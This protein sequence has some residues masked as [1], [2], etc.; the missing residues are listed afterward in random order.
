MPDR[1]RSMEVF[2]KVAQLGS[3][4]AAGRALG[5]SQ[6]MVTKHVVA[7]EERLGV[8][9]LKRSTQRV[10]PT[11]AGAR[12]RQSCERILEDVLDAEALAASDRA[13]PRGLLRL[14]APL[15]F[16]IREIAPI[17]A[18]H[19]RAHRG[20]RVEL[21]LNDRVVDILDEGWDLAIRIGRLKDSALKARRLAPCRIILCASPAYLAARGTPRRVAELSDHDCLG[22]TLSEMTGPEQW[23]FGRTGE[24]KVRISGPM[25]ANN[26][27]AVARA[28]MEGLGIVYQPSFIV[29]E[30]LRRG[31]L[32]PIALDH[33]PV[34]ISEVHA[35]YP[36]TRH[37]SAK[38]RTMI[39]FL[40]ARWGP[41]PPWDRGL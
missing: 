33:P 8:Q 11:E 27:D 9:L 30:A 13:D 29:G 1:L 12:F 31:A 22:Y 16:G 15:S 38:V 41:T 35:V 18:D 40:A 21:G 28:A 26:G 39:D 14:S 19:A 5:L 37:P 6:T 7:L 3:F 36:A 24:V 32:V 20:V 2:A 25:R 4:S 10:T 34:Q 17:L 23:S